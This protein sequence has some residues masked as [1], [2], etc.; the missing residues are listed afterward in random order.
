MPIPARTTSRRPE[1]PRVGRGAWT[2]VATDHPR[3]RRRI[4]PGRGAERPDQE[5]HLAAL[6]RF[7]DRLV[8]RHACVI[9]PA[10]TVKAKHHAVI[11]GEAPQIDADHVRTLLKSIDVSNLVGLRDRAILAVLV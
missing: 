4:P 1:V 6:R 9:N 2:R 11:E 5:L 7:F 8:N 10:A 3:R